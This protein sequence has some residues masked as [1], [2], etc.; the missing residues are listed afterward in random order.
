MILMVCFCL[1]V[2]ASMSMAQQ[3]THR[4]SGDSSDFGDWEIVPTWDGFTTGTDAFWMWYGPDEDGVQQ[5]FTVTKDV[6]NPKSAWDALYGTDPSD[7]D[8]VIYPEGWTSI[9][10]INE[11]YEW[12]VWEDTYNYY[13]LDGPDNDGLLSIGWDYDSTFIAAAFYGS[14]ADVDAPGIPAPAVPEPGSLILLGT[15]IVGL[16]VAIRRR[17]KK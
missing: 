9:V 3:D 16:G 2:T 4:G 6:W 7:P 14:Q 13:D 12:Y 10:L 5:T 11:N 8:Y 15:G 17:M 1:L